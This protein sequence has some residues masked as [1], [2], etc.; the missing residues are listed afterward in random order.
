MVSELNTDSIFTHLKS[1]NV[2]NLDIGFFGL[3]KGPPT[4]MTN[5]VNV[6]IGQ[7]EAPSIFWD[8][9]M[10]VRHFEEQNNPV[11]NVPATDNNMRFWETVLGGAFAIDAGLN[12]NGPAEVDVQNV[13]G[14]I[15]NERADVAPVSN[16]AVV[17]NTLDGDIGDTDGGGSSTGSTRNVGSVVGYGDGGIEASVVAPLNIPVLVSNENQGNCGELDYLFY[18]IADL[19]VS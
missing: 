4:L 19:C 17:P 12:I 13:G 3:R 9:G 14:I 1:K 11:T 5:L 6:P 10:D 8:V 16:E 7:A 2:V 18:L 15:Q